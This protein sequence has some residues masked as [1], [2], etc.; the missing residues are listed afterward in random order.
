MVDKTGML[1]SVRRCR[2][3][4]SR[5]AHPGNASCR[6]GIDRFGVGDVAQLG[7]SPRLRPAP[8]HKGNAR[9]EGVRRPD[10]AVDFET[11]PRRGGAH[12]VRTNGGR[13]GHA[14]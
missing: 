5:G 2:D 3:R 8:H 9:G 7:F 1:A 11:L 14:F 13:S 10:G 6:V 12:P 4:V